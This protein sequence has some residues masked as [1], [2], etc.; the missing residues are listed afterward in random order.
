MIKSDVIIIGGGASGFACAIKALKKNKKVVIL[1]HNK[2]PLKKVFISGGGRCNFTNLDAS[3]ENYISENMFFVKNVL[4]NFSPNDFLAMIEKNKVKYVEKKKNQLFTKNG[5]KEIVE[6]LNRETNGVKIFFDTQII[7]IKKENDLFYVCTNNET[8]EAKSL[9]VATGG[10]S[11]Q[12]LGATDL[13]YKIAKQ[14]NIKIIPY[15]PVLVPLNLDSLEMKEI[16]KLQG[17]SLEAIVSFGKKS[18]QDNILFTHFG[19]SGPAIL[20]ISL[21]WQKNSQI[22]IN[23][24]PNIN[25]KEELLKLRNNS[26]GKKISN[27]L[28]SYLPQKIVDFVLKDRDIFIAEA[29]NK[30]IDEISQ[31]I[32]NWK[33]IPVGTQGFSMAEATAG[34]VDVNELNQKTMESKKIS[35][36]Y[37][38]GEVVDVTGE[39]GGFNLQ[40]AWSSGFVAGMNV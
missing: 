1:E 28:L 24:L 8:F 7:E 33:I 27:I 22:E 29:P 15:R 35:G 40:W 31:K 20:Q 23:M 37:F 9:V 25:I 38:V 11:Y 14:F 4:K 3:D 17:I 32:N 21:H 2:S 5:S 36:L 34:G 13:G 26:R 30:L 19:L 6:M 39:V 16:A 12:N 18:Y 10:M